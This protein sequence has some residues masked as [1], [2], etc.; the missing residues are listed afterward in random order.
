M[1]APFLRQVILA[2]R[3]LLV[4]QHDD[5]L[6]RR[7][8]G[9]H[10]D[11]ADRIQG[12]ARGSLDGG[13]EGL[14]TGTHED[15]ATEGRGGVAHALRGM[16]TVAVARVAAQERTPVHVGGMTMQCWRSTLR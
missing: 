16:A 14:T 8:V 9:R 1:V 3:V 13:Q 2:L 15:D 10:E 12:R 7:L 4:E 6:V 5:A 11:V